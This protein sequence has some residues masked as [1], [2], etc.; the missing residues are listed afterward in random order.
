MT[1]ATAATS[2]SSGSSNVGGSGRGEYE[3]PSRRHSIEEICFTIGD[4][5]GGE[6]GDGVHPEEEGSFVLARM[7]EEGIVDTD[8]ALLRERHQNISDINREMKHINEIQKGK[9]N[10]RWI[11]EF[12]WR[13]IVPFGAFIARPVICRPPPVP[14]TD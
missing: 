14:R 7:M 3:A 4:G 11:D 8:L 12:R 9:F 13:P 1:D 6:G 5:G 10:T 2:G